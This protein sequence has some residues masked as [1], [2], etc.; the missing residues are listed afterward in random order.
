MMEH[1]LSR[2]PSPEPM[3]SKVVSRRA[4]MCLMQ[5]RVPSWDGSLFIYTLSPSLPLQFLLL[6]VLVGVA[7]HFDGV[8][9][10]PHWSPERGPSSNMCLC[11]FLPSGRRW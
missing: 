4:A 10:I 3:L 2:R 6:P 8:P 1:C 5:S 11:A 9:L 7:A